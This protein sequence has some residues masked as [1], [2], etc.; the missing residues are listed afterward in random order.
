MELM[1]QL[2]AAVPAVV[3]WVR[4]WNDE[5]IL[6]MHRKESSVMR[7]AHGRVPAGGVETQ[8]WR[9]VGFA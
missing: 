3:V 9:W 6:R 7:Q 2:F 5:A 1:R 4:G 8:L